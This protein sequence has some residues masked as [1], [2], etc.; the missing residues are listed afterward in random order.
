MAHVAGSEPFS[1]ETA[2]RNIPLNM[3]LIDIV[4]AFSK[5]GRCNT[6][7]ISLP[8][9]LEFEN[10]C[11]PHRSQLVIELERIRSMLI[12]YE[13]ISEVRLRNILQN[14]QRFLKV[15]FSAPTS[16]LAQSLHEI[17]DEGTARTVGQSLHRMLLF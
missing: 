5:G 1:Q 14:E 16:S 3:L 11:R 2:N 9:E 6:R 4:H 7:P 13:L 10:V 8:W 17:N 15:R 12:D